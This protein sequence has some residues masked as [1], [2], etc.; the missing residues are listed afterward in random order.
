MAAKVVE[1]LE[2]VE[3]EELV[4]Q[5]KTRFWLEEVED[6]LLVEV[7]KLDFDKGEVDKVVQKKT[8]FLVAK[9]AVLKL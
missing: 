6:W 4:D 8:G 2:P 7:L 1:A 9:I 3:G 5:N